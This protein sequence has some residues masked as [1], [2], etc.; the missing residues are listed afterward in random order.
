MKK[1]LMLAA[2]GVLA[3]IGAFLAAVT[4]VGGGTALAQDPAPPPGMH[5]ACERMNV[6]AM[7]KMHKGM[8]NA[9]GQMEEWMTSGEH[10]PH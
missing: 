4:L 8:T 9:G 6:G 2:G 1:R 10:C 7:D 5:Q 3:G